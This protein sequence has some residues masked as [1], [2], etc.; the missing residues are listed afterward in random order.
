MNTFYKNLK[1]RYSLILLILGALI[2]VSGCNTPKVTDEQIAQLTETVQQQTI[3]A[4][5]TEIIATETPQPEP[6]KIVLVTLADANQGILD[7]FRDQLNMLAPEI[8]T[9]VEMSEMTPDQVPADANL[10]IFPNTP[11]DIAVYSQQHA[12]HSFAV[13]SLE[14]Q[15]YANVWTIPYDPGFEPFFAGYFI[16]VTA[17]DWR[18]AGLLPTDSPLFGAQIEETFVNGMKYFCGRCQSYGPPYV[19]FPVMVML[20]EG[21]DADGW[22]A[23]LDQVQASLP[24]TFYISDAALSQQLLDQMKERSAA[25]VTAGQPP[26]GWDGNWLGSVRINLG[27]ALAEVIQRDAQRETAAVVVPELEIQ[28][29]VQQS[30]FS[31]GKM[32]YLENLYNDVLTG[33]VSVYDPVAPEVFQP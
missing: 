26:E 25:V 23:G 18:G 5:P 19:E 16:G 13:I 2:L 20:P 11:S 4:I 3:M 9:I 14:Q 21:T 15:P 24:N 29:G 27:N 7:I 12:E 28:R 31:S 33:L 30:L 6:E 8:F 17:N 22:I 32:T 10:V 1:R